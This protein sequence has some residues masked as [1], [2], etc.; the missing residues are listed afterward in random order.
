MELKGNILV[1]GN[2]DSTVKVSLIMIIIF[3]Q[4]CESRSVCVSLSLCLFLK[5]SC[6]RF[7]LLHY[8]FVC[9]CIVFH[10]SSFNFNSLSL[11]LSL[12]LFFSLSLSLSPSL[13]SPS[14]YG[15]WREVIV[16]TRCMVHTSTRVPSLVYSSLR[17]LSLRVAT[18]EAS[19][20]GT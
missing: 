18:M 4:F 1:S 3:T 10:M 9:D 2:A 15:M 20:Y 11:S 7:H 14:R 16:Y 12:S 8:L 19:N 5:F 6:L 17:T 13:S